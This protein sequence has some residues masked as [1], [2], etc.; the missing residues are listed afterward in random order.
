MD[1]II[2][3]E[4]SEK[5]VPLRIGETKETLVSEIN[6]EE[7]KQTVE[8]NTPI[9]NIGF[10]I[11]ENN[12]IEE[13]KLDIPEAIKLKIDDG[14]VEEFTIHVPDIQIEHSTEEQIN[15]EDIED[16]TNHQKRTDTTKDLP[17]VPEIDSEP[18]SS[19]YLTK[20]SGLKSKGTQ[21][22]LIRKTIFDE[23]KITR[24]ELK[25]RL[26]EEGYDVEVGESHSGVSTT[27]RLLEVY[28]DEIERKGR[29]ENKTLKW[30]VNNSY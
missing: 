18:L 27:L 21:P 30:I 7:I 25:K 26:S 19:D 1:I 23:G 8:N 29:G 15:S 16:L 13:F 12:E 9:Q 3:S 4:G 22:Y 28:T 11:G 14:C 20:Y 10:K 2:S 6:Q 5:H 17:P 24:K